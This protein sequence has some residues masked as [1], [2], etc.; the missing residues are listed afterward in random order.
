MYERNIPA[1]VRRA[2]DEFLRRMMGG[3]K[4]SVGLDSPRQSHAVPTLSHTASHQK[5]GDCNIPVDPAM[6]SLAMVY[7]PKQVWRCSY[8]PAQA[9]S[10]GTLFYELDKPFE[11]G[12][13]NSGSCKLC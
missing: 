3:G 12:S 1:S 6:P 13:H 11:G 9:L 8:T 5:P 10:R 7:A 4:A 2:D